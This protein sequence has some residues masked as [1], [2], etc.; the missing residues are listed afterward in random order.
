V[1]D[2]NV[3]HADAVVRVRD[4]G[5]PRRGR[6]QAE[7]DLIVDGGVAIRDGL[8]V[9][10]GPTDDVLREFGEDGVPSIDAAGQTVL[11]G[12][13]ESHCHPL[14]K[15]AGHPPHAECLP[16][17]EIAGREDGIWAT[18]LETRGATD[19][20]LLDQLDAVYGRAIAGGVTT[21]EVKSGYSLN[22]DGEL[23]DLRLLRESRELTPLSLV[24]T[25]L[26]AHMVPAD[27][28]DAERYMDSVVGE[29]L[30]VVARDGLAEF[31]DVSCDAGLFEAH[32]VARLLD[33][34][35]AL[36]IP[37][38]VHADGWAAADGWRT[39][40]RHGAVTADHLTF[41][42]DAEIAEVG[43]SETIATLLPLAEMIYMTGRRANA[44]AFID[45]GVPVA[46]AT[47][48]CSSL[49]SSSLATTI[50]IAAPW[51][52]I[53]PAE[54]IVGATL[55]AAYSLRLGG[56]R[57]SVDIGK[58][59]DLTILDVRHPNEIYLSAGRPLVACVVIGGVPAWSS[60][61]VARAA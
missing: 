61:A 8:I 14:F 11:P 6:E 51:F 33:R 41:T 23:R 50:G 32:L 58:R 18:V 47:D 28:N 24:S 53:K 1:T 52:L 35:A 7:L 46:I 3:V 57:G 19:D 5:G 31:A 16:L 49:G 38:R 26:G 40:V 39:A 10:V 25:F 48:Y 15:A 29:M 36:G 60:D 4:R 44:R 2:L 9:A 55:N 45:A 43:E 54:A 34:A 37:T 17:G 13:V 21:L 42:P 12:L 30:P 27:E 20:E 22:V 56:D 59:G